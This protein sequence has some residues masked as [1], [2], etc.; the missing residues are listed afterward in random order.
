MNSYV[1]I[2]EHQELALSSTANFIS[3]TSIPSGP[4]LNYLEVNLKHS[5]HKYYNR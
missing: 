3:S 2:T 4:P 1:A 5:V